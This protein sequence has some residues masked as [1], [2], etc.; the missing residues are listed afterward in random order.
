[1][2]Q[3]INV[4][5]W[6]YDVNCGNFGDELSKVIANLYLDHSKYKLVEEEIADINFLC[7]GSIMMRAEDNSVIWGSGILINPGNRVFNKKNLRI[8]SVRGPL[9]RNYLMSKSHDVP[10][11]YGDPALLIS[12]H[13]NPNKIEK[14][15]NKIG[16]VPHWSQYCSFCEKFK[17]STSFCI[18]NPTNYY[19]YVIQQIIS[20]KCIISSSLHGLIIADSYNIPNLW[21]NNSV[22]SDTFKYEDYFLSQNRELKFIREISEFDESLLYCE[23]NN[24]D[25]DLLESVF[26]FR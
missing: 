7:V 12:R 22:H 13:F 17:D 23:G 6:N 25:L 14:L 19:E 11:I 24:I 9:T 4:K 5:Y 3:N 1:M 26:P 2:I 15:R 20:C 10:E 18:I 8:C 16:I 21:L